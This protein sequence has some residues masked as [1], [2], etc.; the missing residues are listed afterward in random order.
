M[1]KR[2]LIAAIAVIL[3]AAVA[4]TVWIAQRE[5]SLGILYR[6]TGPEGTAYLLGSI[7]IGT[8]ALHPFGE[9]I[10][11]AMAESDV[12]VF[13]TDTST[14]QQLALLSARQTLSDGGSLQSILGDELMDDIVAAYNALG[15]STE[16]LD[17]QKPW[18]VINTLAVYSSAAEMGVKDIRKAI[19][20]GVDTAVE[21]FADTHQK[22]LAYLESIDEI[23]DTMESF[24]DALNRTLLQDEI[25]VI[26]GRKLAAD[27]VS[28]ALWPQ[29]WHDG[30]A[31]AFKDYYQ[32][33]SQGIDPHLYAEYQ[34]K[35]V[36]QRN[37]LMAGRLDGMLQS[38]GRYFVT[39]GLLHLVDDEHDSI[40]SLLRELGYTVE[41]IEQE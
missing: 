14:A 25:D 11:E 35:L 37:T 29:W 28:I 9:A 32:N 6:V 5:G 40:P 18:S 1:K 17:T 10:T 8:S 23:A 30:D 36:I 38:G 24:S 31:D 7:H 3:I 22:T 15:L 20:L 33:S 19:S 16:T 41:F 13:E 21:D 2:L 34:E 12:F 4:C 27:D 26:L 39:V